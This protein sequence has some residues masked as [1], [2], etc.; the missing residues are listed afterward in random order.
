MHKTTDDLR[1]REIAELIPPAQLIRECPRSEAVTAMVANARQAIHSILHADDD[2]LI[3][4]IGP[5]SIHDPVAA[6]EYA[7]RLHA[8]RHGSPKI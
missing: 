3:V 4:V 6:Q 5:C 1:I 8:Q 7:S 2:R